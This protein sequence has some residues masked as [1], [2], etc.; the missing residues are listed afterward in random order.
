M[1]NDM[2]TELQA[3]RIALSK[4][5]MWPHITPYIPDDD[6][7][8]GEI[9]EQLFEAEFLNVPKELSEQRFEPEELREIEKEFQK[10]S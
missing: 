8:D 3:K 6:E 4:N 10:L 2:Q 9:N 1:G 7:M 5:V